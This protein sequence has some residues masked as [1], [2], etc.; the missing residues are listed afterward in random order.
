MARGFKRQG[1]FSYGPVVLPCDIG[2]HTAVLLPSSCPFSERS[3]AIILLM[4]TQS[5]QLLHQNLRHPHIH[6]NSTR[7]LDLNLRNM[8]PR[9][10]HQ[11]QLPTPEPS[12]HPPIVQVYLQS[13]IRPPRNLCI[14]HQFPDLVCCWL[15]ILGRAREDDVCVLGKRE[16]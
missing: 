8:L 15:A 16:S 1:L 12:L 10:H 6:P 14:L 5:I 13:R 7:L 11:S 2:Y 4:S 9:Q 3:L